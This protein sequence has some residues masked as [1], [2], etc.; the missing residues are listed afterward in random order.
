MPR[1]V[2]IQACFEVLRHFPTS[3][4]GVL[5]FLACVPLWSVSLL[6]S[7]PLLAIASVCWALPPLVLLLVL[8]RSPFFLPLFVALN[9]ALLALILLE[10]PGI[11]A[12]VAM[13]LI[14]IALTTV[15]IS[16]DLLLPFMTSKARL[17]RR[18]PRI[19]KNVKLQV[20]D[21]QGNPL[22][23][24]MED[25]STSGMAIYGPAAMV[26]EFVSKHRHL[27]I[28]IRARARGGEVA[29]VYSQIMW[30][31]SADDLMRVGVRAMRS[32]EMRRFIELSLDRNV[33][34][35]GVPELFWDKV[36]LQR[37]FFCLWAAAMLASLVVP[38]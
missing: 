25:Y 18:T 21:A 20:I 33:R 27:P 30:T 14:C 1:L 19:R 6:P 15:L 36:I 10:V 16:R 23:M 29:S 38:G 4:W 28:E 22:T 5:I 32:E 3:L 31:S 17:W 9:I 2:S 26:R 12:K 11:N 7:V 13:F 34:G 8:S 24:R 35:T 37:A